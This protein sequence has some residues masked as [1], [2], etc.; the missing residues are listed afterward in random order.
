M[1]D[2]ALLLFFC[3]VERIDVLARNYQDMGRGLWADIIE[4]DA[5]I[6]FEDKVR[7]DLSFDNFAEYTVFSHFVTY[8]DQAVGRC[9]DTVRDAF[10]I[11]ANRSKLFHDILITAVDMVNA[12]DQRLPVRT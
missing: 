7:R 1:S 12:V 11:A 9:C 2:S 4:R 8:L 3:L 6:V 5:G 10:D